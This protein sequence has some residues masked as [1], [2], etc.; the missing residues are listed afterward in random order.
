MAGKGK[1]KV[2][3]K[4]LAISLIIVGILLLVLV[5]NAVIL[6]LTANYYRPVKEKSTYANP[7]FSENTLLSAH[8]AGGG[9]KPEE[10]M[11]AFK[12]CLTDSTFQADI[13][14]FDLH[15]TKDGELVLLHDDTLDRT[16]NAVE[17]FGKKKAYASNYTLAELKQLNMGENFYDAK[18]NSYPYR[19]LRGEAIPDDI[20]ILTLDE[21]LT[22]VEDEIRTDHTMRYIIEIKDG[23]ENGKKAMDKLYEKMQSYNITNRVIVGTFKND[24]TKYIDTQYSGKVT[25][26]ASI[27][28][29]LHFY[30]SFLYGAKLGSV[31]YTVLQIPYKAAWFNFGTKA[32]I[33]YAHDN[34]IAVQYWTINDETQMQELIDNGADAI[35]TDYP[36]KLYNIL[37]KNK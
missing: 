3:R 28:E 2:N 16:S 23:K 30:F 1:R 6:P 27:L 7:H 24:V 25:R 10:T 20:K 18:T 26:S 9:E 19:G 31:K 37:Q 8:R 33:Q 5:L 14:E 13:L 32:I 15:I 34:G 35:M 11:S 36:T 17:F 4:A 22:Y 21:I 12:L 29:V